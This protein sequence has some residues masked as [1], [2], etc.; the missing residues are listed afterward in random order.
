MEP[1]EDLV[2]EPFQRL[3]AARELITIPHR[4]F[5]ACMDTFKERQQLED[6]WSKGGAPWQV[7]TKD[8][9]RHA[10]AKPPLVP[11]NGA[12][13]EV[14]NG[15][16]D[17]LALSFIPTQQANPMATVSTANADHLRTDHLVHNLGE[18]ALSGGLVTFTAQGIKFVLNLG[19]AAVLARL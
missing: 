8:G 9:R 15:Q 13:T 7:W 2:N 11:A 19:S 6:L 4:G 5:W 17:R 14:Q 10:A 16:F 18:R 12:R 1:G 3:I